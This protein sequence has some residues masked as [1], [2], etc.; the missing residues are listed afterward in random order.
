MS[1]MLF[2]FPVHK[3]RIDP[4]SYD[5]D[6][7][8]SDI[9]ENYYVVGVDQVCALDGEVLNKPENPENAFQSLKKLSGRSHFQN[10][11]MAICLNGKILWQS[12]SIAELTMKS[13]SDKE[14]HDYIKLDEPFS[15]S[16]SYKFESYGKELFT[17]VLGTEYT[18]QGLDIDK[19]M[20]VLVE[21]GIIE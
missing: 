10:C 8:V 7:I 6:K 13:L 9:K 19:L 20:D 1:D 21:E 11:G 14:I 5:K 18:I 4:N 2:G 15:C 3:I 17:N 12:F 16:G